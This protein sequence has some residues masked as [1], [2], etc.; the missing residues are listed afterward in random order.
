MNDLR[1]TRIHGAVNIPERS[2]GAPSMQI[3]L[4]AIQADA[5]VAIAFSEPIALGCL[6]VFGVRA[7]RYRTFS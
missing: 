6:A 5:P 2:S 7:T 1:I 4:T 3:A